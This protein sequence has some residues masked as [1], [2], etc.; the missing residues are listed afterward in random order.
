[1]LS[2]QHAQLKCRKTVELHAHQVHVML[3]GVTSLE[4]VLLVIIA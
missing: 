3:L 1:M 2:M 4:A